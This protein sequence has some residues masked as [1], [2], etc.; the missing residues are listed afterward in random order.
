MALTSA[1]DSL[2]RFR[3]DPNRQLSLFVLLGFYVEAAA[4]VPPFAEDLRA[5]FHGDCSS[6]LGARI[7]CRRRGFR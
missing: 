5:L 2:V 7:T 3:S 1:F 6:L 4:M